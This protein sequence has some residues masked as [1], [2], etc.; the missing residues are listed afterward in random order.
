GVRV[1]RALPAVVE[2]RIRD[3]EAFDASRGVLLV[4]GELDAVGGRLPARRADREVGTDLDG[5]LVTATTAGG[6]SAGE[7]DHRRY[8]EDYQSPSSNHLVPPCACWEA[9]RK[10]HRTPPITCRPLPNSRRGESAP[11]ASAATWDGRTATPR[12]TIDFEGPA[13][14]VGLA[15]GAINKVSGRCSRPPRP[16]SRRPGHRARAPRRSRSPCS[17]CRPRRRSPGC[18]WPRPGRRSRPP[19]KPPG[20]VKA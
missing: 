15:P 14:Q 6:A 17:W 16:A 4:D 1:V 7:S 11:A 2:A 13:S 8:G 3:V 12:Q 5:A 19:R 20:A 10:P 9:K 18:P